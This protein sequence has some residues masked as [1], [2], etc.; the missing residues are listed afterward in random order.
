MARLDISGIDE[1]LE[2]LKRLGDPERLNEA[3]QKAVNAGGTV[4]AKE[5]SSAIAAVEYGKYATGSVSKSVKA[6]RAKTNQYGVF[7]VAKPTGKDERGVRN[8]EKAAYL[9]YGTPTMAA[10]PWSEKAVR[11]GEA[12]A[13]PVVEDVFLDEMGVGKESGG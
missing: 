8:A 12:K 7:T 2:E 11:E 4:L 13:A 3:A 9:Q 5:M 6:T 1:V 10:R